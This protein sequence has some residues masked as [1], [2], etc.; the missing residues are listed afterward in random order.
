MAL[1]L[2][3]TRQHW[4]AVAGSAEQKEQKQRLAPA[5]SRQHQ[6]CFMPPIHIRFP[7]SPPTQ[8]PGCYCNQHD[9]QCIY[10]SPHRRLTHPPTSTSKPKHAPTRRHQQEWHR[11]QLA[12]R[13]IRVVASIINRSVH[14]SCP[15]TPSHP[16]RA[17]HHTPPATAPCAQSPG[18]S[19]SRCSGSRTPGV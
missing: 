16:A 18:R 10:A 3:T 13:I 6:Q 17:A 1:S 14:D 4:H 15:P 8:T 9:A 11:T 19:R 12:Q 5:P 7:A 2:H